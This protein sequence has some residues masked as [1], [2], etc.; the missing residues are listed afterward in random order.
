MTRG[1]PKFL[2]TLF[3]FKDRTEMGSIIHYIWSKGALPKTGLQTIDG[4][5]L[6]II[7]PGNN[8]TSEPNLF[9][10]AM[11]EIEGRQLCGNVM[12]HDDTPEEQLGL[13]GSNND[14]CPT[15]LHVSL[16]DAYTAPHES[17]SIL[18]ISCTKEL[19]E[20][21]NAAKER[22]GKFPCGSTIAELPDTYRH[23]IFSELLAERLEDKKEII[24]RIFRQCEQRWDDTL[25]KTA[26]RSFGFGI[27]SDIFE[28][29]ANLLN[30]NA[31]GKHSDS[32]TQIEAIFFGQAGLLNDESIPYY[33]RNEAIHNSYYNELKI[34]Y[35]FLCNKFNLESLD[36][37]AWG[38]GNGS[39]HL[40]IARLAT[41]YYQRNLTMSRITSAQTLTEL[42][43]LFS[44]SLNGYWQ[45]HTCFGGTETCGNGCMRQKQV[46]IIIINS[47]IPM[48]YIYGKHRKDERLCE[49]AE[50][51]M[52][53]I[54]SEENSIT[55]KW[56]EQGVIAGCAADSQALLQLH[57]NYCRSNNCINCRFAIHYIKNRL[58]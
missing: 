37:K 27:Q 58:K 30:T 11:I 16:N 26:I 44:H 28:K 17:S 1:L 20:E 31:L 8:S 4:K 36:Y 25:L 42:Y 56:R 33:Y 40:R 52:H 53:E 55:K 13:F 22:S 23:S 38:S 5:D 24:E 18:S 46:D 57:R 6:H 47:V 21:Y 48:L 3:K 50:E 54:D 45:N 14:S 9:K 7:F 12:L 34:E 29:W 39:P 15:I 51:L 41:L 32:L 10:E 43:R 35:S 49:R 2:A 19:T